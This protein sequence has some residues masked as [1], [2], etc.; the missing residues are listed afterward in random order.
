MHVG[1][2]YGIAPRNKVRNSYQEW[3][4]NQFEDLVNKYNKN[5]PKTI[6][7]GYEKPVSRVNIYE[8]GI[9]IKM[10]YFIDFNIGNTVKTELSSKLL[11]ELVKHKDIT[12]GKTESVI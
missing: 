5:M 10:R 12:L 3:V 11:D 6:K 2:I 1:S 7:E 4:I 9:H 8:K